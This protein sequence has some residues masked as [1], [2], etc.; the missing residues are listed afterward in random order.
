MLSRLFLSLNR[1]AKGIKII[2]LEFTT[3]SPD[4]NLASKDRFFYLFL[5]SMFFSLIPGFTCQVLKLD[6]PL[7][8][9]LRKCALSVITKLFFSCNTIFVIL[10]P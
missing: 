2:V 4:N 3:H 8:I 6:Q 10:S 5:F 1:N 9:T 7:T